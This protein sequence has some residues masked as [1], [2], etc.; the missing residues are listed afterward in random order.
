MAIGVTDM[1]RNDNEVKSLKR[2]Y[3]STKIAISIFRYF[4]LISVS[5]VVIFQLAYMISYAFRPSS[6]MSDPSV[7]WVPKVFTTANFKESLKL[8]DYGKAFFNTIMI[9]ILSGV[10]EIL[11]CAVAAYGFARFRCCML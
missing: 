7:V 5:Y 3:A 8:L 9:Q 2:K 10:A 11:T 6:E 1:K 4:F